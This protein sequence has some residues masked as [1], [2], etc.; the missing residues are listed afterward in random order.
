M[1]L[2]L[3]LSWRWC[4]KIEIGFR[5]T[6]A[7]QILNQKWRVS[8][9]AFTK[10]AFAVSDSLGFQMHAKVGVSEALKSLTEPAQK[11]CLQLCRTISWSRWLLK[12]CRCDA[13]QMQI[14]GAQHTPPRSQSI[15]YF[16]IYRM[17]VWG[18]IN[19]VPRISLGK[20][21][22]CGDFRI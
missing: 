3:H 15:T 10:T 12:G 7:E 21:F 22:F 14:G 20:S 13:Q 5:L 6:K 4:V 1:S 19:I 17:M 2:T 16:D 11:S 8:K 9:T 18:L